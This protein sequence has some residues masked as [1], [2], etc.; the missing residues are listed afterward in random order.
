M[1]PR[2]DRCMGESWCLVP[3]ST[4]LGGPSLTVTQPGESCSALGA[5]P[6]R[7]SQSNS[8]HCNSELKAKGKPQGNR[9]GCKDS[10]RGAICPW[11]HLSCSVQGHF[12]S[13][14]IGF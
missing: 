4:V 9:R 1:Y 11:H 2:K 14:N 3:A 6:G 8:C 7:Q 13:R 12:S 5:M 10:L